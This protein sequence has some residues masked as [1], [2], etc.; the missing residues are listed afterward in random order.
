MSRAL[1]VIA[2]GSRRDSANEEFRQQVAGIARLVDHTPVQAAFLELA[3]PGIVDALHQLAAGGARQIDVFPLFLNAGRH[4]AKDVPAEVAEAQ[5]A[6]PEVDIRLLDYLG[7]SPQLVSLVAQLI[8][9]AN[10]GAE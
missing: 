9:D 8:A 2:H 4:V 3:E 10:S 7:K 5:A 1:L 6:L